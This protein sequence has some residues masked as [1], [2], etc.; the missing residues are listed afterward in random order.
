MPPAGADKIEGA[1][2][3]Q[4]KTMH[5]RRRIVA[6]AVASI[7][8]GAFAN[9]AVAGTPEAQKWVD[10]EFQSSTLSKQ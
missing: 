9:Q 7:V 6:L 2:K 4:E 5:Q 1:R 8:S 3:T 10:S